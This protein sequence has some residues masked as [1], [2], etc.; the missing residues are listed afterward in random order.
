MA[1]MPRLTGVFLSVLSMAW[2]YIKQSYGSGSP[3]GDEVDR[4]RSLRSHARETDGLAQDPIAMESWLLTVF[5]YLAC[6][7]YPQVWTVVHLP[8]MVTYANNPVMITE[9]STTG[10]V[11]TLICRLG[12]T[13]ASCFG[14]DSISG[15]F[16]TDSKP[17][18]TLRMPLRLRSPLLMTIFRGAHPAIIIFINFMN[19]LII[20]YLRG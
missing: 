12:G 1:R 20:Y 19:L 2:L 6:A 17:C 5:T 4:D 10:P 8:H 14:Q 13:T 11:M 16:I 18:R 7:A 15:A 9:H 3:T